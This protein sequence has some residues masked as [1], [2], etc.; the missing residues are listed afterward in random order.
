MKIT[1]KNTLG[2]GVMLLLGLVGLLVA[3]CSATQ[4]ASGQL[5]CAK[6]VSGLPMI[7]GLADL[8][9]APIVATGQAASIVT[10]ECAIVQGI[11]V[12][13]PANPAAAPVVAIA[14]V[15]APAS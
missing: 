11:P 12:S 3:G 9:G 1:T 13:P 14:P 5:Y 8:A 7:V 15:V 4:V 2:M 6:I 10:A